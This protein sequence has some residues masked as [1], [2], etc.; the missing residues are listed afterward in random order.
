MSSLGNDRWRAHFTVQ[1]LGR[2]V[3]TVAGWVDH[4]GTWRQ[5]LAK[6]YEAGQ[7]IEFDLRQGA[8]LALD[9][10]GAR[11]ATPTRGALKDWANAIADPVR[12]REERVVARA[13]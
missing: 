4:M 13:K 6:K 5:G 7:D 10:C 1:S 11:C 3:F 8:A 12:D 9:R 2:Y